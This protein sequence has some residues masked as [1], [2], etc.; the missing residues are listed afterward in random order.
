MNSN[1]LMCSLV[2]AL[3]S[4][5]G[6]AGPEPDASEIL[7]KSVS[8]QTSIGNHQTPVYAAWLRDTLQAAGFAAAEMQIEP[9][10]DGAAAT[11]TFTARWPGRDPSK[12]PLLLI[13][14]MDVVTAKREDWERDP[15]TATV[16]GGYLYGRGVKDNKFDISM[17]VAALIKL[18]RAGFV[19]SRDIVLALTG[20][21]ETTGKGA[22]RLA[23]RYRNAE[24]VLNGDSGGGKLDNNT[25][26]PVSYGIQGGEKTYVDFT[27][28]IT[29]PGGHSARPTGTNAIYK[30]SNALV[31][32]EAYRFPLQSNE[33]TRGYF[34]AT[35]P[36]TPGP[37]GEFMRRYVANPGDTAAVEGLARQPEIVG[38]LRTTCVTTQVTGGHAPNA[39]PQ[40]ATANVNCRIFPG[41]TIASVQQTLQQVLSEPGITITYDASITKEAP[42]SPLRKDVM[43]AV[44]KAVHARFPKLP[45]VPTMSPG[46]TD[47]RDY[48]ALGVPVYGVSG[49]FIRPADDF[50]HGLNERVPL[51]SI[52]PAVAFWESLVR[53]LSR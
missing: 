10:L 11:A 47:G 40:R 43:D 52:E 32:L 6:A 30:L 46:A 7:R 28:T 20:D 19:P 35:A 5:A 4:M 15:F 1:T 12:K 36:V 37:V 27:L 49:L 8:F 9:Q 17:M 51:D 31:R 16:D 13:G 24:L 53:D 29:D 45:I 22:H 38:L 44:A 50:A 48:R 26:A 42:A 25:G 2:L 33:L 14:H 21:E 23:E 39:L 3:P 41:T 18:R 34:G